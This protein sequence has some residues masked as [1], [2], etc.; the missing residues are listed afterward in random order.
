M[1]TL[2][3]SHA[4]FDAKLRDM[5]LDGYKDEMSRRGWTT[6]STF[7][8]ASSWSP[9]SGDDQAF[10][11]QVARPLLG[12]ADHADLPKLRKLYHEAYTIVAAELRSRLEGTQEADG[13]KTRKLPPVERKTRWAQL[14]AAYAH[15]QL[16]DQLEP[17]HH[18]VDKFHSMRVDGELRYLAPHEVPTRD[19]EL[20][21]VKTE[22][23]IKKD[24]SGHLRAHD[25]TKLPEA[26]TR[27]DLRLRQAYTRRGLAL[28]VADVMSFTAHEKLI[29]KMFQEYQR[30]PPMGYVG[31]TL[32]QVAAA[33]RKAWKLMSEDLQGD[34]GRDGTGRRL[35]DTAVDRVVGNPAFLT[36]LLP[37]PGTKGSA[38]KDEPAQASEVTGTG[39]GKRKLMKENQKL[40]ERLRE[41]ETKK[42]KAS[43]S[44]QEAE[45]TVAPK[46]MP[47]KMP[48][49]LW[50]LSPMKHGE[51]LCYGFQLGNCKNG[52]DGKCGKGLHTCMKCWKQ[53]HGAMQCSQ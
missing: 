32:S 14:K 25:E 12:A 8:F 1:A 33:D 53:G 51:R 7:A 43:S 48:K 9:G 29:D 41:A 3:E 13:S 21:N 36:I 10:I 22:E 4:V 27:T 35:A 31:V 40:K 16:S 39:V 49:E 52:K 11:N 17:A 45:K 23:L 44:N 5:G 2:T 20:H 19:Q 30:E 47:I 34:L 42:T 18:V 24:A 37:L 28:E 38:A 26:D 6:M 46:K 50:G 15:L